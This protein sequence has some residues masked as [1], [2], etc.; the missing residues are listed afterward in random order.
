MVSDA[1]LMKDEDRVVEFQVGER[2]GDREDDPAFLA[3]NIVEKV[4]DFAL[5]ARVE[6]TGDFVA[7]K[8][9]GMG[10]QFH[11]ETEASLLTTREDADGAVGNRCQ[12]GFF[13][14]AV[15]AFIEIGRALRSDPQAGGSFDGFIYAELVI[16]DGELRWF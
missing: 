9:L 5:G 12:S 10:D 7:E 6:T 16:G 11:G 8:E 3:G 13:K 1:A 2:V 15:N 4:Y 14:N